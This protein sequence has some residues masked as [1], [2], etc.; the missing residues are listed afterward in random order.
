MTK[1]GR[2]RN[3]GIAAQFKAAVTCVL[4]L[5]AAQQDSQLSVQDLAKLAQNPLAD[6]ISIPF[7]NDTNFR[8][9]PIVR[10]ATS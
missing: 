8:W 10:Q 4:F 6:T 7:T 2:S 1:P 3:E 9:G 5:A